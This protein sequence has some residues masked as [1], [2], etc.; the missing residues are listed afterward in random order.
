[1]VRLASADHCTAR[2]RRR[3][4][5]SR[6]YNPV[7]SRNAAGR[8][9]DGAQ[10]LG[11]NVERPVDQRVVIEVNLAIAVEIAVEPAGAVLVE[12]GVDAAVVVEVDL[13]VEVGVAVVGV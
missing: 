11:L 4:L 9:E 2:G 12:A 1:M 13:A 3:C 6:S 10:D 7:S 5:D 8:S